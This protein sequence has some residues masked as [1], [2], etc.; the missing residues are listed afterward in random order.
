MK[1]TF[2]WHQQPKQTFCARCGRRGASK[3]VRQVDMFS[4]KVELWVGVSYNLFLKKSWHLV[5]WSASIPIANLCHLIMLVRGVVCAF[6]CLW[7]LPA[8]AAAS[9]SVVDGC[10]WAHL[11]F[12]AVITHIEL[13]W[14]SNDIINPTGQIRFYV[15]SNLQPV[16]NKF[17]QWQR[18]TYTSKHSEC[19]K[20][21][22]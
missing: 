10:G 3:L 5:T 18:S 11:H 7:I 8:A 17:Q 20:G 21:T 22:V 6:K 19:T 4:L 16:P 1:Q 14:K 12:V 15:L 13:K 9:G 2:A